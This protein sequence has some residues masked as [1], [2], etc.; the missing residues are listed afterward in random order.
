MATMTVRM[1]DAEAEM[2]RRFAAFEGC[3]VSDFIRTAVF[4]R[5]EDAADLEALEKAI[6]ADDGTSFSDAEARAM[7]GF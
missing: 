7:L 2:V 3:T 5:M 6:A 4:E 1:E